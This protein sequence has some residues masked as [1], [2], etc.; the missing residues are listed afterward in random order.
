MNHINI[1]GENV[2]NPIQDFDEL[3]TQYGV[4]SNLVENIKNCGYSTPTPIQMQAVP[5][6]LK[7]KHPSEKIFVFNNIFI[8]HA[9]IF[10]LVH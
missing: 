1:S 5:A 2:P 8:L 7:V 3:T 10:L 9:V 4:S 6:M